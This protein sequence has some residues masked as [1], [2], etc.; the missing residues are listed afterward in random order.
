MGFPVRMHFSGWAKYLAESA[1]LMNTFSAP[2]NSSILLARPGK[3]FCSWM[4]HGTPAL[5][6]AMMTVPVTYP[7]VP[8]ATSGANSLMILAASWP[9]WIRFSMVLMFFM[10]LRLLR[11]EASMPTMS[12]PAAGTSLFSMPFLVPMKRI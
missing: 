6:A 5:F 9:P 3:A 4:K 2:L 12:K 7:P 8:M 1:K 11:P 10:M